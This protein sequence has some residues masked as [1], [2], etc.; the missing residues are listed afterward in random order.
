MQDTSSTR[1]I[2]YTY[3]NKNSTYD[4]LAMRTRDDGLKIFYDRSTFPTY[5]V[6]QTLL[7]NDLHFI[8]SYIPWA[9]DLTVVELRQLLFQTLWG[10]KSHDGMLTS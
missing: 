8:F 6:L 2:F 9:V 7:H 10:Q 1:S 4:A 5:P 3:L